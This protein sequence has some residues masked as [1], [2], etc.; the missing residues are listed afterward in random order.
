MIF[1]PARLLLAALI[2]S[3]LAA[4]SS[5]PL[6]SWA[7]RRPVPKAVPVH[8]PKTNT[9]DGTKGKPKL[10]GIILLVNADAGFVVIDAHGWMLPDAGT[11]LKAIR[12]GAETGIL[13][14]GGE[15]Q[16]ANVV[17][18]IVTGAPKK[19]DQVFQ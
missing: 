10:V 2:G 16:G 9:S 4:C 1:S 14:V 12:D 13:A 3:S 11:A 8:F 5:V 17:A 15:R 18:D 19:G 7:K 6:P